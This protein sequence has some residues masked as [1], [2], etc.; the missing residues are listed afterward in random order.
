MKKGRKMTMIRVSEETRIALNI[1]AGEIRSEAGLP[2]S[3]NDAL[4]QLI[5]DCRKDIAE[6]ALKLAKEKKTA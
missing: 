2:S 6:R 3:Q 5:K 1:L 4:W